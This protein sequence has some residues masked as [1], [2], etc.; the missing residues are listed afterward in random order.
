MRIAQARPQ[1]SY[2]QLA[3]SLLQPVQLPEIGRQETRETH[4]ANHACQTEPAKGPHD[5]VRSAVGKIRLQERSIRKA[6]YRQQREQRRH[7]CRALHTARVT[8]N[9][10]YAL[11]QPA[12]FIAVVIKNEVPQKRRFCFMLGHDRY[13]FYLTWFD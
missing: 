10:R 1:K 13:G 12:A 2:D 6:S 11:A 3:C 4:Q 8:P 5:K 7:R 9:P